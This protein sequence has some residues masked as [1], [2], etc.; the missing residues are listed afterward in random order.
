MVIALVAT[1]G[2]PLAQPASADTVTGAQM[3]QRLN[4][5][6]NTVG[7]P[8]IAADPRVMLAA[9]NHADYS[10]RNGTG[11]HSE[12]PALPGYTGVTPQDRVA[13]MG[14]STSFVSEVAAG[15]S[16]GINALNELWDAPY[17]RL[18]LM[19]PNAVATGWGHSDL[20]GRATTVGDFV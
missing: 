11:G 17:H 6:R 10:S 2:G 15:Y 13:A 8:A 9:Q 1:V 12:D 20:N 4:E 3:F 5:L 14:W 18:G 16:G 19:H 7:A